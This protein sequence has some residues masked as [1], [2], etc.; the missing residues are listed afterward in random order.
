MRNAITPSFHGKD[1]LRFVFF[2]FFAESQCRLI[3]S[4]RFLLFAVLQEIRPEQRKRR[5]LPMILDAIEEQEEREN[6]KGCE[7]DLSFT[8]HR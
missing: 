1:H 2:V 5:K 4:S 6:A 3:S 8:R 7:T